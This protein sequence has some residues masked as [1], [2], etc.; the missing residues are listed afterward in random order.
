MLKNFMAETRKIKRRHENSGVLRCTAFKRYATVLS[1][2]A[3][4]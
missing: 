1:G 3:D 2:F 4:T